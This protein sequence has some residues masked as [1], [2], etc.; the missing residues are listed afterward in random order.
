MT[1]S[2][3]GPTSHRFRHMATQKIAAKPLQ[4]VTTDSL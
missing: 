3:L 2:N 1:S 4:M